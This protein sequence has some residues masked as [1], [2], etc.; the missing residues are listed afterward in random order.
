MIY[1]QHAPREI[2]PDYSAV[3]WSLQRFLEEV[4]PVAESAGVR[5][6]PIPTILHA[7]HAP[8]A[9]PGYQPQMYRRLIGISS[10]PAMAWSFVWAR[11]LK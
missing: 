10:S 11:S 9:S 7:H 6:A 4:L 8:A 5:L 3:L 1:D 2:W